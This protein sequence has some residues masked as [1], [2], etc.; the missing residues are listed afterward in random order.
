MVNITYIF[1]RDNAGAGGR[2]DGGGGGRTHGGGFLEL[3]GFQKCV[4]LYV[5]VCVE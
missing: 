3:W 2:S 4:C 5:C 1:D